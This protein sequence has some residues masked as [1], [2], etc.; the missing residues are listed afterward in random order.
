[1]TV[2][3]FQEEVGSALLPA[4]QRAATALIGERAMREGST[5]DENTGGLGLKA[6][7]GWGDNV[8]IGYLVEP[9]PGQEFFRRLEYQPPKPPRQECPWCGVDQEVRSVGLC[10]CCGGAL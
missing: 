10:V 9:R 7:R 4:F 1:M 6:S 2:Q 5:R 8:A 3:E